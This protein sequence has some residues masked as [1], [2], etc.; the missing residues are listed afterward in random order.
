MCT[1]QP[2]VVAKPA[3]VVEDLREWLDEQP[4]EDDRSE[5][6]DLFRLAGELWDILHL[7]GM[8]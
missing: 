7:W 3:E 8:K 1:L 4:S 5:F 2:Q 6:A